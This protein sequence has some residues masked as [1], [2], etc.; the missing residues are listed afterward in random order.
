MAWVPWMDRLSARL[1]GADATIA[2]RK[3]VTKAVVNAMS[4]DFFMNMCCLSLL[5]K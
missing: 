3:D 2:A 5:Q 1:Q 4:K